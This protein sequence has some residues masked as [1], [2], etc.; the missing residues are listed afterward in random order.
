[1]GFDMHLK[2]DA[3]AWSELRRKLTAAL[4][5]ATSILSLGFGAL[6]LSTVND[7]H[8]G[9]PFAKDYRSKGY[10]YLAYSHPVHLKLSDGTQIKLQITARA[11]ELY[12]TLALAVD[13]HVIDTLTIGSMSDRASFKYAV[14]GLNLKITCVPLQSTDLSPN[15]ACTVYSKK[16][17]LAVL[18][19]VHRIYP[20]SMAALKSR[21][22]K[23]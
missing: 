2:P 15:H 12:D 14:N 3:Y 16:T 11:R 8:A 9:A 23:N 1:M 13:D 4:R 21:H 7:T 17:K 6:L 5:H 22:L 10:D 18:D 19:V 20:S